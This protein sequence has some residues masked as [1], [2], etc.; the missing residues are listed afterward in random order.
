MDNYTTLEK[1]VLCQLYNTKI[2]V[3]PV[4]NSDLRNFKKPSI[5][6]MKKYHYTYK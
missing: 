2:D 6:T 3:Y 1:E 4:N 5:I